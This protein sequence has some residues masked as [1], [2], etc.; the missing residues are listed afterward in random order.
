MPSFYNNRHMPLTPPEYSTGFHS[1][2]CSGM[3]YQPHGYG[4]QQFGRQDEMMYDYAGR[5]V[6][7]SAA[8]HPQQGYA[9][10]VGVQ[11]IGRYND[12]MGVTLPPVR[13]LDQSVPIDVYQQPPPYRYHEQRSQQK[14]KDEKPVGG[15]SAKLDYDMEEMT[16]F[17]T[18]KAQQLVQSSRPSHTAFRAWV[19]SVLCATR[20]PSATIVLSLH[21]LSGHM[22]RLAA[23]S[24]PNH[25]ENF[26]Y[27]LLTVALI[28]GSKF[29]DDN[30]FINR[31]WADV[32]G[33][34]IR[35]LNQ[36]ER[37]WL[38]ELDWKL[39]IDPAEHNGFNAWMQHWKDYEKT[40]LDRGAQSLKLSPIDT[41]VQHHSPAHKPFSP[42]S[43]IMGYTP[44]SGME[45][46]A[47]PFPTNHHTPVYTPFD[48]WLIRRSAHDSSPSSAPH[49]GPTTPEYYGGPGTWAPIDGSAY[50]YSRRGYQINSMPQP[51]NAPYTPFTPT[52]NQQNPW[53]GHSIHCN[54][55][56]CSRQQVPYWVGPHYCQQSVMA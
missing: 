15:V 20:L 13:S 43:A 22:A 5:Y 1:S 24:Q 19:N 46:N 50:S 10:S 6:R 54:C 36:M 41:N 49:T 21:Y 44:M 28:M 31:S 23:T 47:R 16:D 39:H 56:H 25:S 9:S 4:A 37:E 14:Q 48:P 40:R 32:S 12:G 29:L 42:P 53:T 33:I 8:V 18:E 45:Y 17:V 2:H 3:P 11:S 35:T 7:A 55:G 52:Y 27:R 34:D 51:L 30:T 26:I 38:A